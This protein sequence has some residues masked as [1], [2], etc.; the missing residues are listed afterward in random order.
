MSQRG[1]PQSF[2]FKYAPLRLR[3]VNNQLSNISK[4]NPSG[5]Q[6]PYAPRAPRSQNNTS[7]DES[8]ATGIETSSSEPCDLNSS[9][10]NI[11]KVCQRQERRNREI[12]LQL[13][14]ATAEMERLK[15]LLDAAAG[16]IEQLHSINEK[17]RVN[18]SFLLPKKQNKTRILMS[19]SP[20]LSKIRIHTKNWRGN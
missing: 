14:T 8:T 2:L 17:I 3:G 10:D 11:A 4:V 13:E 19:P 20:Y 5:N 16:E 15:G 12:Q 6:I 9:L 18:C 1:G 7:I